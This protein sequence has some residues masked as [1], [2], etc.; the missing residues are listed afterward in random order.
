VGERVKAAILVEQNAP[1]EVSEIAL[2]DELDYGQVR[3]R[4]AWS[5]ICGAQLNEIQGAKGPDRY[6][7]HLLGHEG[8]GV[9]EAIG[10]GVST[11]AEGDRVVLHWRPSAGIQCSPPSYD[12]DGR[13]V[14]AGWVTTFN[15]AAVVSENRVTPIPESFDMRL[16]PLLGCA[17]TTGLGVI[18]NEARVGIGESVVVVG[19]GGVGL[20]VV[21]AAAMASANPVVAVDVHANKLKLASRLGATHAVLSGDDLHERV[22]EVV[23]E[24]GAD[25]VVETTGIPALIESAYELAGP[26]GRTIL[27]GVPPKGKNVRIY[28]L[29]LHFRKVLKGTEGGGAVPDR[30]IP[31]YIAL[32]EA[33]RLELDPLVTAAYTLHTINDAIDDMRAGRIAGR[34]VVDLT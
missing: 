19:V 8:S 12:W 15:Q 31:R 33:G 30:D 3:V 32:H 23:G 25:V 5:G 20:T 16:A 29:P 34:C 11:V 27:V 2:P 1:L 22:L 17:V 21:Q 13:T 6:L 26:Q 28:T 24:S 9:V 4:L 10:P 18:S 14:N 7:P